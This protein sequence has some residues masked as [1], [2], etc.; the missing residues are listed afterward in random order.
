M[1]SITPLIMHWDNIEWADLLEE[2]RKVQDAAAKAD[3][4]PGDDRSPPHTWKGYVY[5]DGTDVAMPSENLGSMLMKAGAKITL[6]GN[7]TFKQLS[8]SGILFDQPFCRFES[9]GKTIP[10]K[11]I[12]SM[13][14]TFSEQAQQ[15]RD[16]GFRLLVKRAT[17][18]TSK[19]VRIRPIFDP[20][21]I[22]GSFTVVSDQLTDEIL[23]QLWQIGGFGIGTGD[24]RPGAPKAPG[25][26]GRSEV[27]LTPQ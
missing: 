17:V 27:T 4:K 2:Q 25:P 15:V 12:E 24:W 22:S 19:H 3:S 16:A 23:R 10:I 18:G 5:H 9:N 21:T 13:A 6:K 26:Y 20:W 8:Q 7:T 1:K 11:L 14:G